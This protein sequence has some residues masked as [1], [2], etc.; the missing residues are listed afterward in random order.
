[1]PKLLRRGPPRHLEKMLFINHKE[2]LFLDDK[3]RDL[4]LQS[5]LSIM[6]LDRERIKVRNEWRNSRK[7][8]VTINEAISSGLMPGNDGNMY[9][10]QPGT[11]HGRPSMFPSM[12]QNKQATNGRRNV[13]SAPPQRKLGVALAPPTL[14]RGNSLIQ[15]SQSRVSTTNQ[16]TLQP[17]IPEADEY[18]VAQ[19]GDSGPMRRDSG[20]TV[21]TYVLNEFE[22]MSE[23]V[24]EILRSLAKKK[25]KQLEADERSRLR[26]MKDD[27]DV[28]VAME[29][30]LDYEPDMNKVRKTVRSVK[31]L[32]H[33]MAISKRLEAKK[34]HKSLEQMIKDKTENVGDYDEY[35][36]GTCSLMKRR[37]EKKRRESSP[38]ATEPSFMQRRQSMLDTQSVSRRPSVAPEAMRRNSTFPPALGRSSTTL[39]FG[40][41]GRL[42]SF[43]KDSDEGSPFIDEDILVNRQRVL[44]EL[45]KYRGIRDKVDEFL[46]TITPRNIILEKIIPVK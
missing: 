27:I 46:I 31:K 43:G 33:R 4:N 30:L 3:I 13:N 22:K 44:K 40:S 9:G 21:G 6:D 41:M 36:D 7:K 16:F 1:M 26:E 18:M 2:D 35:T 24:P 17:T 34:Q 42:S 45:E 11:S 25:E 29:N 39:G 28:N 23:V 14:S 10:D 5:R 15:R 12:P 8:Q 32:R 37:L 19:N 38:F 20:D